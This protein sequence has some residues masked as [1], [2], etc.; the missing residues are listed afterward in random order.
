[1]ILSLE[2][3]TVPTPAKVPKGGKRKKDSARTDGELEPRLLDLVR[4]RV[5]QL[6]GWKEHIHE[7]AVKLQAQGESSERLRVLDHW[8]TQTIFSDCEEAALNLAEGLTYNP[9]D[10]VPPEVVHAAH[11]FFNETQ[12][13]R[14]VLVILAVN[15]WYYLNGHSVENIMGHLTPGV[16][17]NK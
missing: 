14:L 16:L 11:L 12:M 10:A 3:I 8:W 17:H 1:M 9:I 4:L 5:L 2:E 7:Q 15:D 6:H 13:I